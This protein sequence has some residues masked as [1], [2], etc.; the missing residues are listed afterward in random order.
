MQSLFAAPAQALELR[1][2][3]PPGAGDAARVIPSLDGGE[4]ALVAQK[5]HHALHLVLAGI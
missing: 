3:V 4:D 5:Q 2:R 1:E